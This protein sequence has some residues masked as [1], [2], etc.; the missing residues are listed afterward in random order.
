[1]PRRSVEIP[2]PEEGKEVLGVGEIFVEFSDVA[3]A[4]KG[5][6]ALAGRKFSGKAVKAAFY[7]KDLYEVQRR[8]IGGTK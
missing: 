8:S 3:G 2:R 7:P 1:M 6:D 5:R 4:T